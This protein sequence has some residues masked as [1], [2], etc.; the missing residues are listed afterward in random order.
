MQATCCWVRQQLFYHHFTPWWLKWHCHRSAAVLLTAERCPSPSWAA[1][2]IT[3]VTDL[4]DVAS[5]K[6][7]ESWC[8]PRWQILYDFR[9]LVSYLRLK[10]AHTMT[11]C[12]FWLAYIGYHEAKCF[13][14]ENK[15]SVSGTRDSHVPD[16]TCTEEMQHQNQAFALN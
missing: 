13:Q 4:S 5:P 2:Q 1:R 3:W 11:F 6:S 9:S 14:L 10:I 8:N 12:L 7:S 15:T 16:L